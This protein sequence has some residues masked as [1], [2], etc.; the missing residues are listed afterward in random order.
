MGGSD[1]DIEIL[2]ERLQPEVVA[3][4]DA[5]AGSV[6][7]LE[8]LEIDDLIDIVV[9]IVCSTASRISWKKWAGLVG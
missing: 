3:D 5:C 2:V 9:D 6:V 8:I 1:I 4:L 7:V